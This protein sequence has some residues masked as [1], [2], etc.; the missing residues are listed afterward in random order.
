M[1]T[2][3]RPARRLAVAVAAG[4]AGLGAVGG[5]AAPIAPKAHAASATSLPRSP[6]FQAVDLRSN[7]PVSLTAL[8]GRPVLL[9]AW[10]TWCVPCRT[11][12]PAVQALADERAG[13]GLRV[14][15]VNTDDAGASPA[16]ARAFL[17]RLGITLPSWRDE[18]LAFARVFEAPVLPATVLIDKRGAV[19]ERWLGVLRTRGRSVRAAID[20][21]V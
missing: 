14:V 19:A 8:R 18:R 2:P 4:L 20:R 15:L 10:S 17:D 11:E 21:V 5:G 7:A 1:R 16:R 6:G 12:L 3:R 13:D 9:A